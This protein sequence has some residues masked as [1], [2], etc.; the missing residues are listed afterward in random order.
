MGIMLKSSIAYEPA[1]DGLRAVAIL[2]VLV[3]HL[4]SRWL[5]GGFSGVDV[6]FV[7]SGFLITRI[8]LA[9]IE[10]GS[11]QLSRYYQKR[12][13]RII[14]ASLLVATVTLVV[15]VALYDAQERE[16][17]GA[18]YIAALLSIANI[19][20]MRQENYFLANPD[21][22][23]FL[24]YWSLSL[25]EQFY[26]IF[27]I[28][29]QFASRYPPR[30]VMFALFVLAAA[31]LV[32]CVILTPIDQQWAFYLLPS[33][34]WELLS[35]AMIAHQLHRGVVG[36]SA[37]WASV[38]RWGGVIGLLVSFVAIGESGDFPGIIALVPVLSTVALIAGLLAGPS[39]IGQRLS[40]RLPVAIGRLSYSLY[41]WH[42]PV[43]S[44]VDYATPF[45][46]L[47]LR[48]SVKI[49][50]TIALSLVSFFTVETPMR[51]TLAAPGNRRSAWLLVVVPLVLF[52]PFA[53]FL[54]T[55]G[56]PRAYFYQIASGGRVFNRSA[57]RRR[58]VLYGDSMA[59]VYAKVFRE[60][61]EEAGYECH[62]MAAQ[63]VL[64]VPTSD[65]RDRF[66]TD[67]MRGVAATKPD[68]IFIA[69]AYGTYVPG[70]PQVVHEVVEAFRPLT[71]R[72]VLLTN[73]PDLPSEATREAIRA[74]SRPPFLEAPGSKSR[75]H[76]VDSIVNAE[77]GP[78]VRVINAGAEFVLQDGSVRALDAYGRSLYHD[79]NHLGYRGASLLKSAISGQ[80]DESAGGGVI[81][82][83]P[84]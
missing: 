40:G 7:L 74:G 24:H 25:E 75:R 42:W 73:P 83:S 41:L 79:R 2:A 66:F 49:V 60:A 12:I 15:A 71:R 37:P 72:L 69:F 47:G 19:K 45:S 76:L 8:M 68:V 11:F 21:A 27:P 34:G 35:G 64:P 57:D 52:L 17:S 59:A 44:F 56:Y 18:N 38:L 9:D 54:R 82:V 39:W 62:I 16:S 81:Q 48:T 80:L 14:P 55:D 36:C 5:P 1:L 29:L 67:A 10:A 43:F 70:R 30:G 53:N 46:S 20:Q 22:N 77:A 31:S 26:F 65:G 23:P 63:S 84:P 3:Y 28:S 51:R 6:F 4:E 58:A 33:R 50:A 61:C 78:A 32:A 13:A